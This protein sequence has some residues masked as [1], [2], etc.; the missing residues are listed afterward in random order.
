MYKNQYY[1]T[2]AESKAV[3]EE[4]NLFHGMGL[5]IYH[6]EA[7][8]VST[9]KAGENEVIVVGHIINPFSPAADFLGLDAL[10]YRQPQSTPD[11]MITDIGNYSVWD[12]DGGF[13]VP[14]GPGT[15]LYAASPGVEPQRPFGWHVPIDGY[16]PAGIHE[17]R[18][19]Y[20]KAGTARPAPAAADGI[21]TSWRIKQWDGIECQKLPLG[22]Y[23]D[24]GNGWFKYSEYQQ[25]RY[26]DL[27]CPDVGI[28]LAVWD[29][30]NDLSDAANDEHYVLWLQWRATSGGPI[31]EEPADHH[32]QPFHAGPGA[33]AVEYFKMSADTE[34][35]VRGVTFHCCTPVMLDIR[36]LRLRLRV[37]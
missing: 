13:V 17:F 30:L 2:N 1:I 29:T 18:V 15:G 5:N 9:A 31:L 21:S 11:P 37:V 16:V 14:N 10:S 23:K 20:R 35:E 7:L 8:N 12:I 36:V 26:N 25:H 22:T 33:G 19:V 27:F 6:H 3:C 28:V 34:H 32:I 24:D 4:I